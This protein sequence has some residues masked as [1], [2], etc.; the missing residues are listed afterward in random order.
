MLTPYTRGYDPEDFADFEHIEDRDELFDLEL[1]DSECLGC[2]GNLNARGA[3]GR[4]VV[5]ACA[6][7]SKLWTF[8]LARPEGDE[9]WDDEDDEE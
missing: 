9:D 5:V 2:G 3:F 8:E 1:D 4:Q 6:K 7:C